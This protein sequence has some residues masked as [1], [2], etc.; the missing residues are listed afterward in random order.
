MEST[1]KE[2][3][4]IK[5]FRNLCTKIQYIFVFH[6]IAKFSISDEKVLMLAELKERV[7]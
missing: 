4:N 2:S 1:F 3:K 6:D 5:R 7:T